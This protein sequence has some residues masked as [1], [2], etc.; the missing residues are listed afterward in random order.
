MGLSFQTRWYWYRPIFGNAKQRAELVPKVQTTPRSRFVDRFHFFMIESTRSFDLLH[1][2]SN[3]D[4]SSKVQCKK[5]VGSMDNSAV[6]PR[7]LQLL[8]L[9]V[10]FGCVETGYTELCFADLRE[11]PN[12]SAKDFSNSKKL[13]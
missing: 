2:N 5:K 6:L 10:W 9:M 1:N 4:L 3:G 13:H 11:N 7:L 12:Q 8:L